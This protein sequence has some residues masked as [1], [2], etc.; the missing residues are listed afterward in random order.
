MPATAAALA[1]SR[2]AASRAMG[3]FDFFGNAT[4]AGPRQLTGPLEED[5]ADVVGDEA[6][7]EQSARTQPSAEQAADQ[8]VQTEGETTTGSGEVIDLT[9]H[10][11][12]EQLDLG[13]LRTAIS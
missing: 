9:A 5:L 13:A 2:P 6:L 10:D 8:A 4:A 1:P 3:G 12:T 7:A 11:E